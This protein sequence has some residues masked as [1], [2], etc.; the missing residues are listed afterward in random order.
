[1]PIQNPVIGANTAIPSPIFTSIAH[2]GSVGA[3][4]GTTGILSFGGIGGQIDGFVITNTDGNFLVLKAVSDSTAKLCL[5][6]TGNVGI[7]TTSPSSR[8]HTVT[9]SGEN[10]L[11]IEASATSQTATLSLQTNNTIPGQCIVYMGRTGASTNGQVGY[12]PGTDAL[13][14]FTNNAERVRINSSGNVGIGTASPSAKLDIRPA[15]NSAAVYGYGDR[16][17]LQAVD[18]NTGGSPVDVRL[19]AYG[20]GNVVNEAYVGTWSNHPLSLVT[21]GNVRMRIDTSGN[22]TGATISSPVLSGTTTGTYT[23][24]GTPSLAAT[25]LT[26]TIEVARLGSSGSASSGTFL[27]GD[28]SWQAVPDP[29]TTGDVKMTIKTVADSGWVLMNDGTI[30]NASSGGTTRANADTSALFQLLWNNTSNADCAVS[31][32][33]G[34]SAASDF[35]ANKTISLPKALG[36]ALACYGSGSGLTNRA[37]AKIIGEESHTQTVGE[38]AAHQHTMPRTS[39]CTGASQ[40]NASGFLHGS[41]CGSSTGNTDSSGS[42]TPH[43][44]MQPTVFLNIM[45]KL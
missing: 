21:N 23:L 27:R 6:H 32:G 37:M 18:P 12:D 16:V 3:I 45:I 13:Y 40:S 15:S 34:G 5:T 4:G 38:M 9:A 2:F 1:M 42:N 31:G 20:Q 10:K 24:G 17:Y 35:A 25:A 26:G 43:N 11:I 36:R 44:V 30:G 41:G 33:R 22:I 29:F 28:N 8:L 7:G 14:L 39:P 19:W